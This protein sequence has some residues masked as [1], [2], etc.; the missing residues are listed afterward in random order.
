[1]ILSELQRKNERKTILLQGLPSHS[2]AQMVAGAFWK[3]SST[4]VRNN[5]DCKN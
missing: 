4:V 3:S 2:Q 5:S 1:M